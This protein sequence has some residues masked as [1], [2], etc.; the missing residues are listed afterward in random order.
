M[1]SFLRARSARPTVDRLARALLVRLGSTG[2]SSAPTRRVRRGSA[3]AKALQCVVP[4]PELSPQY[5]QELESILYGE[6]GNRKKA[7]ASSDWLHANC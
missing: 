4:F 1:W 6:F 3:Q 5:E 2:S 7:S